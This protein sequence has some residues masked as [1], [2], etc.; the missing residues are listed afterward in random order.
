MI[1]TEFKYNDKA[2]YVTCSF[3]KKHIDLINRNIMVTEKVLAHLFHNY[4][5]N[6]N[7]MLHQM[8]WLNNGKTT[9]QHFGKIN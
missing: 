6:T 5:K 3:Q 4:L 7:C 2:N 8:L 9:Q 1:P